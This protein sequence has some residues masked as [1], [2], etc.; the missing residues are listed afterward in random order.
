MTLSSFSILLLSPAGSRRA[1]VSLRG[2]G[3]EKVLLLV[4]ESNDALPP[5]LSAAVR[6]S[7]DELSR[8]PC[9]SS[10]LCSDAGRALRSNAAR[11]AS[12]PSSSLKM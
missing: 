9:W 7:R 3:V 5:A 4:V 12:L 8:F 2:D 11:N 10:M 1:C 6:E